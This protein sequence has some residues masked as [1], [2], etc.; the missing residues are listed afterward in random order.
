VGGR[1]PPVTN[2]VILASGAPLAAG[3]TGISSGVRRLDITN[4]SWARLCA[5]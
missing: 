2:H 3:M 1:D 4:V 5:V